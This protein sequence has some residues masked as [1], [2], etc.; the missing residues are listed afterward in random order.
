MIDGK[1]FFDQPIN[2][3]SKTCENIIKIETGK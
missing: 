2:N 1:T 3:K